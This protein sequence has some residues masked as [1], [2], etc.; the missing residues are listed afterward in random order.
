MTLAKGLKNEF[1]TAVVNE[2]SVFE[3][4]KFYK[5]WDVLSA[6]I[7][8]FPI[9]TYQKNCFCHCEWGD[10][11]VSADRVASGE[12]WVLWGMGEGVWV[13]LEQEMKFAKYTRNI[14][15]NKV[16]KE[17]IIPSEFSTL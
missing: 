14:T 2:P 11:S 17:Q 10:M 13:A 16:L 5:F 3:P 12:V 1:E 7:K 4:L 15:M 6:I 9:V 8:H